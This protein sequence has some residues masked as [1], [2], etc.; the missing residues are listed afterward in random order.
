MV[1]S[2]PRKA[3]GK[4]LHS[5]LP[6]RPAAVAEPLPPAPP[7]EGSVLVVPIGQVEP[8][9]NQPRREF[10]AAALL[11][12]TQSIEREG[13]IQPILVRRTAPDHFQIIAGERRWRAANAAGL[14]EIPVIP[15]EAT[16]E[17]VLELAIVE[18]IQRED[19]N[20]IELAAAFHRM[21]TELSLSHEQIGERTG[22]DRATVT[23]T[24][25]LLHL[26]ERIRDMVA[27]KKITQGHA[28]ALLKIPDEATQNLLAD[29]IVQQGWS[30]RQIEN[31]TKTP[32]RP[33]NGSAPSKTPVP[34]PPID[35]NVKAAVAQMEQTLGTRV[36]IVEK[37][38][39][40]GHIEIEYYTEDD[41]ERIYEIIVGEPN[42]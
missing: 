37:G 13:V 23:N 38:R 14:T 27:S 29:Q 28:R 5:L 30:V 11:E 39:S 12:L 15:R 17:Q 32:D 10:D 35:P 9:P 36:R 8:N 4:G 21:A 19:L 16:D 1:K 42:D 18:N 25:R 40:K 41:L 20:P 24:M 31:F 7:A 22:K 3:L 33:A 6:Q 26:P 2:D 34:P